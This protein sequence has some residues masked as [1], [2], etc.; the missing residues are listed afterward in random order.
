MSKKKVKIPRFTGQPE[1]WYHEGKNIIV[2]RD[3]KH[4]CWYLRMEEFLLRGWEFAPFKTPWTF[5]FY[6]GSK[7]LVEKGF[8]LLQRLD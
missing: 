2:I 8:T 6:D 7:Y 5:D 1:M 3:S 4:H